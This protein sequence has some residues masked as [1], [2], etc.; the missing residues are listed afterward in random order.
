M[1]LTSLAVA[2]A[3]S[4]S[5]PVPDAAEPAGCEVVRDHLV[6]MMAEGQSPDVFDHRPPPD[7][8]KDPDLLAEK[9]ELGTT[10]DERPARALIDVFTAQT[11]HA[12]PVAVCPSLAALLDAQG[13]PYSEEAI[14]GVMVRPQPGVDPGPLRYIVTMSLPVVSEDGTEALSQDLL[15]SRIM[16]FYG[17]LHFRKVDGHWQRVGAAIQGASSLT[18]S[19]DEAESETE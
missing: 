2:V 15:I 6:W 13:I 10:P 14:D 19:E 18:W 7:I 9:F 5:P 8:T 4:L 17:V 1:L 12:A 16:G 3:V 11:E